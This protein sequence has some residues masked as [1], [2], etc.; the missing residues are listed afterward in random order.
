VLATRRREFEANI[1]A[2][3]I[4]NSYHKYRER[5]HAKGIMHALT[6]K[7]AE[8]LRLSIHTANS[9]AALH[10]QQVY[11]GYKGKLLG[12]R[13]MDIKRERDFLDQ[14]AEEMKQK[15]DAELRRKGASKKKGHGPMKSP[16]N[17]DTKGKAKGRKK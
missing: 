11:R 5:Y 9:D 13:Q 4:Q 3:R 16:S 8:V 17:K 7:R 14:Q 6:H 15:I 10:I 2:M 12:L 1:A